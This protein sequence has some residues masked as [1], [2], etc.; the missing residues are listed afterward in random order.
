[1]W[2]HE[3]GI[4]PDV[5][6]VSDALRAQETWAEIATS[7]QW[8]LEPDLLAALYAAGPESVFDLLRETKDDAQTLVVIGHIPTI[9]Y[10]AELL[11]DGDGDD[12]AITSL[13]SGGYPPCAMTVFAVTAGWSHLGSGSGTLKSFHVG[14]H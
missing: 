3:Q 10:L 1:M 13:V 9:A 4:V 11:D 2:L 8:D 7:A 12:A 6:L 5:A 14:G